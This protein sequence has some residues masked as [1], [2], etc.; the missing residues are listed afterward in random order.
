MADTKKTSESDKP[1]S[2]LEPGTTLAGRY[3]LLRELGRGAMGVVWSAEDKTAERKVVLKFVML[4]D[5]F[6]ANADSTRVQAI[7]S[8]KENFKK[9]HKLHHQHICPVYTLEE[10]STLGYYQ[11]MKFL[12]GVS[13]DQF[14]GQSTPQ[15]RSLPFEETLRILQ[16]L[17]AALDYAHGERVIHRDI[18]PANIFVEFDK[19][20][21]IKDVQVIDFGLALE[22]LSSMLYVS[23]K[24]S[25]GCGSI[26]YSPPEQL[27]GHPLSGRTDQ[28]ALAIVAYELL[29]GYRPFD[30]R[31]IQ[32]VINAILNSTPKPIR[33]IANDANAALQ[34]ALEKNSEVRFKNCTEFIVALGGAKSSESNKSSQSTPNPTINPMTHTWN[35]PKGEFA[36]RLSI[37]PGFFSKQLTVAQGT[38]ALIIDDGNYLGEVPPG[39]YTLQTFGEI[40]KF[41]KP[42][43]QVDVI[44]VRQDDVPIPFHIGHISTAEELL[45]AVHLQ[46]VVQIQDIAM[47]IRNLLG[48]RMTLSI[49]EMRQTVEPIIT[50]ALRET[51]RQ[52]GIER[53]CSPD[54]RPL[55]ATGILQTTENSLKRYGIICADVQ[56]AEIVNERYDAQRQQTGEI[57][58]LDIQTQQQRKLDE[59]LD[60]ETLRQIEQRE[61]ENELNVLA[62]NIELDRQH[63]DVALQIRGNQVR[64]DMRDAV[65]SDRFDEI[66]DKEE[67]NA[68]MLQID[69]QGLIRG[70]EKDELTKLYEGKKTDREHIV[71]K[72][73]LDRNAELDQ[74]AASIAH[75]QKMKTLQHEIE[76]AGVV[77]DEMTR[78]WR[79]SLKR[80]A[81]KSDHDFQEASKTLQRQ[82]ELNAKNLTFLNAEEWEKLLQKQKTT[83]LEKEIAEHSAAADVR[84]KRIEDEYAD[85]QKRREYAFEKERNIDDYDLDKRKEDDKAARNKEVQ[86]DQ[87]A[88]MREMMELQ[89]KRDESERKDKLEALKVEAGRDVEI[90]KNESQAQVAL[91]EE[92]ARLQEQRVLD[93]QKSNEAMLAF[94]GRTVDAMAQAASGRPAVPASGQTD[95]AAPRVV[96]CVGCRA[97]NPPGTK[98]CSNCG[99]QL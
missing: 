99:K 64:K 35:A 22:I 28:Y 50:Q 10:D 8:L 4:S 40:L 84:R 86:Q 66:T 56:T 51:I 67:F 57:F 96:V 47:F 63:A 44:L 9:I 33:S 90:S 5:A 42:Q 20:Q 62:E 32:A 36:T 59:V 92:A 43:K 73:N 21:K 82:H 19:T 83:R 58:L 60:K 69:K 54:V 2:V 12:D 68:F 7:A 65:Q 18:K 31:D 52:L 89:Q 41:W 61:R 38:R 75:T 24:R 45:V 29:S 98:F 76:L 55:L 37:G 27:Q 97:E 11:V 6:G 85:E 49:E 1:M 72:L 88:A 80:E 93:A 71:R 13:L 48:P 16:P 34:K 26:A 74:I 87:M 3:K 30:G 53:L 23:Q 15:Q 25:D 46:L 70:D 78:Q 91:R 94:A 77:E 39:T 14:I 95:P 81:E 17:A 79:E